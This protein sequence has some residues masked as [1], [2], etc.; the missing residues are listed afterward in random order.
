M[1]EEAMDEREPPPEITGSGRIRLPPLGH[2][3]PEDGQDG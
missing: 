1:S 3:K 2:P